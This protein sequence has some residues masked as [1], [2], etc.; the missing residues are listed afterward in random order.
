MLIAGT[1]A[2]LAAWKRLVTRMGSS[3]QVVG[4]SRNLRNS[5][6]LL[7][8]LKPDIL[9][10]ETALPD[11]SVLGML[12]PI[13]AQLPDLQII[14][15]S[16]DISFP[17]VRAALRLGASD[18]LLQPGEDILLSES[19]LR[20]GDRQQ[21]SANADDMQQNRKLR[22]KAQLLSL[23]TN[24]SSAGQGVQQ[25]MENA[26]LASTAYYVMILQPS[27]SAPV[28]AEIYDRIDSMLLAGYHA[29]SVILYDALVVFVMC[30]NT[31][32]SWR[33]E[34]AEI[35][36]RMEELL[37]QPFY[38]GVSELKQSRHQIR[39]SY[40]QARQA[41]WENTIRNRGEHISYFGDEQAD[42]N[43]A[44]NEMRKK[45][46][47]L[48]D[49]ADL[50]VQSAQHAAKELIR[51]SG[52]QY[53]HL[54]AL[55]SLYA[56]MLVRRYPGNGG[57]D[58]TRAINEAW[59]VTRQE[60]VS[61]CLEKLCAALRAA[62]GIGQEDGSLL[63]KSILA[64]IRL[65]GAEELTLNLVAEKYHIS[66]NYLSALIKKETGTAYHDHVIRAKIELAHTLLADPRI[67]V[68]EVARIIGYS[69]YT[70]FY[71]TFKRVEKCTPTEYRNSLKRSDI[72]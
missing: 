45:V 32:L 17:S 11:G 19:L 68:E 9:L 57:N 66:P 22:M 39:E 50:S 36:T 15:T 28:G 37:P 59:F 20:A 70:S 4:Q 8:G 61:A 38:A 69:N 12:E 41:V 33:N 47:D 44:M 46:S 62:N 18:Y 64:Y 63:V 21:S 31:D 2:K 10:A 71:N 3:Y 52:S 1:K 67:Q 65:H 29:V 16:T 49:R 53:S 55:V 30:E 24:A 35:V 42:E 72:E 27:S 54:R 56:I 58:V 23:L 43:A 34:A 7:L 6:R 48:I 51:V 40:Q 14:F 60:D 25:M 13:R 26:G 5:H